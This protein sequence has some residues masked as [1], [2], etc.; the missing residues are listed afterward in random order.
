MAESGD[1]QPFRMASQLHSG[2][3]SPSKNSFLPALT[4]VGNERTRLVA[5]LQEMKATA[6]AAAKVRTEAREQ[7][8]GGSKEEDEE[9]DPKKRRYRLKDLLLI[10]FDHDKLARVQRDFELKDD[11]MGSDDFLVSV[12]THFDLYSPAV[13]VPSGGA[14]SEGGGAAVGAPVVGGGH[15]EAAGGAAMVG[16]GAGGGAAAPAG[17]EEEDSYSEQGDAPAPASSSATESATAN[18]GGGILPGGE[19]ANGPP[20]NG[21]ASDSVEFPA[22]LLYRVASILELFN[23]I[24]VFSQQTITWEATSTYLIEHGK[25]FSGGDKGSVDTKSYQPSNTMD[26]GTSGVGGKFM[27]DNCAAVLS[28]CVVVVHPAAPWKASTVEMLMCSQ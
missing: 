12:L 20:P 27:S 3:L 22:E 24:D 16:A 9:E 7:Q 6:A 28:M 18:D 5:R 17:G 25:D 1:G 2:Y 15:V 21:T 11:K 13:A 4:E 23:D 10:L 19:G 8:Q 14:A 26:Q